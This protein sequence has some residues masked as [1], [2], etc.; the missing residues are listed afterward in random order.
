MRHLCCMVFSE[1]KSAKIE[2][3]TRDRH[4]VLM[5]TKA[6]GKLFNARKWLEK[7][8]TAFVENLRKQARDKKESARQARINAI[9]APKPPSPE[10]SR[11]NLAQE[12]AEISQLYREG[13]LS[14]DE[15]KAA[16]ARLI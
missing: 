13:L 15:F 10:A 4:V 6:A 11:T 9:R 2:F 1:I 14:E 3:S 12:L 5:S 16:K 8:N 7:P